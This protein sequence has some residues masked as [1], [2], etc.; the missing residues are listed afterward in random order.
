MSRLWDGFFPAKILEGDIY[1]HA[2]TL[3][4]NRMMGGGIAVPYEK[5]LLLLALHEK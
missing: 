3:P 2:P 1:L 5:I 4:Q